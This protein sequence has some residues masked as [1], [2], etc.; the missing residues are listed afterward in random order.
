MQR[1]TCAVQTHSGRQTHPGLSRQ[2]S[3]LHPTRAMHQKT[4]GSARFRASGRHRA[5]PSQTLSFQSKRHFARLQTKVKRRRDEYFEC[6]FCIRCR[7][8]LMESNTKHVWPA[9][10][11]K[12]PKPSQ[13]RLACRRSVFLLRPLDRCCTTH[14][15]YTIDRTFR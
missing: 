13:L 1:R 6:N 8:P 15:S 12:T 9:L 14:Q 10:P 11:R 3:R 4:L 7:S 5:G 2:T